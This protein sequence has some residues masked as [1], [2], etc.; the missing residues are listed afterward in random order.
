LRDDR[1]AETAEQ[2]IPGK[3]LDLNVDEIIR[4]AEV[5]APIIDYK[6]RF[7]RRHTTQI[8]NRAWLMGGY[9]GYDDSLRAQLYMAAA[10]HDLGKLVTPTHILEKP[11]KLD[12]E[13]F[14]II[15]EHVRHTYELLKDIEGF[16]HICDWASNHHEKL[17][18]TGYPFGKSADQL[19]FNSRL[20][21]CIDIY[22]AVCEARPYH[23]Q[24]DHKDTM[25]ILYGMAQKGFVDETIVKDLDV[26]MAP[27]ST[28]DLPS[29]PSPAALKLD[30]PE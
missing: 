2:T 17:D 10:F 25:S 18:G 27:Y 6:S 13:E 26:A 11:G 19:D 23:D 4:V 21:A 28:Q 29:F 15:K 9:Y 16:G 14:A 24:R 22:Q 7:T 20:L 12:K 30:K 1:I 3:V 5:V 8:A